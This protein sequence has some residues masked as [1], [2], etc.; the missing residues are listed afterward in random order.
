MLLCSTILRRDEDGHSPCKK[1]LLELLRDSVRQ[2]KTED[3][4]DFCTKIMVTKSGLLKINGYKISVPGTDPDVGGF[5]NGA[6]HILRQHFLGEDW[7]L[8]C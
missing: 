6:V 2:L 4:R 7:V 8:E 1:S 3:K 5:E